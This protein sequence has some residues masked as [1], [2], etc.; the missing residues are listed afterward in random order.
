MQIRFFPVACGPSVGAGRPAP[1]WPCR[2]GDR[3]RI[4]PTHASNG[5]HQEKPMLCDSPL[6]GPAHRPIVIREPTGSMLEDQSTQ[7][8]RCQ[9]SRR[10]CDR[11]AT[12]GPDHRRRDG[13]RRNQQESEKKPCAT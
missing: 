2:R 10:A 6:T 4:S 8:E 11:S 3:H 7:T 5:G 13:V 9:S 12:S 1:Q